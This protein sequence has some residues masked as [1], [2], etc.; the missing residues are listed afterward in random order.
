MFNESI[1]A[2]SLIDVYERLKEHKKN[3]DGTHL[4][5]LRSIQEHYKDFHQ[6]KSQ[7][8]QSSLKSSLWWMCIRLEESM[9][10]NIRLF[11]QEYGYDPRW[12]KRING[13]AG[14]NGFD[15][16]ETVPCLFDEVLITYDGME[17][18]EYPIPVRK[19]GKCGL[20]RP[21]GTGTPVTP[22]KYDLLF[23]ETYPGYVPYTDYIKYISVLDGK[24]GVVNIKGEEIVPC[25]LDDIFER[26]DTDG[27][28][29]VLKDGKWGICT[30]NETF[31]PPKFDQLDIRS[32]DY[33]M[34]RIGS[35]WGWVTENGDLT[36]DQR[37]A[38][39][40]SW[41]DVAK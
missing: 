15:G 1:H 3:A 14:L 18:M 12:N 19:D 10:D 37:Q 36:E 29:P 21:D 24:F 5:L 4:P 28:L 13:R 2:H 8:G 41:Y 26:Q 20:V 16:N 39:I 33:L 31:I 22:F 17:R 34:A 6:I 11:Q 9:W 7:I 38:A 30:D 25:I 40:G 23:R 27:F 32:E 35:R